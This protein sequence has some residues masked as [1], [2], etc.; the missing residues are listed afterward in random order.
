MNKTCSQ[1]YNIYTQYSAIHKNSN[2]EKVR[3][4][5][6]VLD[7]Y[8]TKDAFG[9]MASLRV[10]VIYIEKTI[11]SCSLCDFHK[12]ELMNIIVTVPF[13]SYAHTK[14]EQTILIERLMTAIME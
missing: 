11:G 2:T 4:V 13:K 14:A 10:L 9:S 5:K 12:G 1:A 3:Y 7:T 8:S 6:K